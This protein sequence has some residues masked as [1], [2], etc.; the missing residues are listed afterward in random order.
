M[1][2]WIFRAAA[3]LIPMFLVCFIL[4]WLIDRRR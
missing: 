3:V 4:M 1:P 2:D